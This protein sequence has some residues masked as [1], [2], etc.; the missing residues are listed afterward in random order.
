MN[1]DVNRFGM[2]MPKLN[3]GRKRILL[4]YDKI[5]ASNVISALSEALPYHDRN[6]KDCDYLIRYFLGEQ[7]ILNRQAPS[8]SNINN[9]VVVNYAFSITRE[10]VGYTY[11]NPVEYIQN[12]IGKQSDV[13]KLSDVFANAGSFL[14]DTIAAIYDSIC[15]IGYQLTLP[16][17]E[18]SEN[19]IPENPITISSLDPRDCFVAFSTSASNPQLMSCNIIHRKNSGDLYIV[20]TNEYVFTI[21]EKLELLSQ[22]VNAIGLDPITMYDNSIFLTGD[23]EQAISVMNASNIVAS[24]SLNDIEGAIRSLLVLLG[25][26]FEDDQEGLA[27]I[28]QKRLLTL[29]NPQGHNVD[30][31]FISPKVDSSSI[32]HIREYL[33]DARNVITGIPDRQTA[34]GGDTGTAVLNRN[35]WTDIEIV[36]KLKELFFK[37]AKKRQLSVGIRILQKLGLVDDS[38]TSTNVN[39]TIG[40]H[41]M[42]N[43]QS[44]AQTFSTLVATGELAT[45]DALEMS[46]LTNRLNEV[47]ERGEKAKEDAQKKAL[48]MAQQST[49]DENDDV[50]KPEG[51][52]EE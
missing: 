7:D 43:I 26:E 14:A 11:G 34:S 20:Y 19:Y 50:E 12:D 5:D 6:K 16:S 9:Q 47:V 10:I 33:E 31:K 36:A 30:A 4:D 48:E 46:G 38:L 13:E 17:S 25:T 3:Y 24:D 52:S 37:K 27:G 49:P 2:L 29:T 32:E 1:N 28:K 40:R 44:K 8:T 51:N 18:I 39:V 45:I 23:W 15:G 21:S 41:T 22:E 35:G 42:D